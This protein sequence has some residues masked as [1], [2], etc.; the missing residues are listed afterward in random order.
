MRTLKCASKARQAAPT[1]FELS[2][3]ATEQVFGTRTVALQLFTT[4]RRRGGG[5]NE[6][7]ASRR[8]LP[9]QGDP[10]TRQPIVRVAV[11]ATTGG[12]QTTVITGTPPQAQG[13][14]I[15]S[16]D[17]ILRDDLSGRMGTV[18]APVPQMT[19]STR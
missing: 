8:A 10:E 14:S 6:L 11:P 4:L 17:L 2:S 16:W 7:S 19:A 13:G 3:T 12:G 18:T 5:H 9:F 1:A 15:R